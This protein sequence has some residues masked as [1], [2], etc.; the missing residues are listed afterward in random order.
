MTFG[1][2][3]YADAYDENQELVRTEKLTLGV[4]GDVVVKEFPSHVRIS[5][6][7]WEKH[8]Q[9]LIPVLKQGDW[10]DGSTET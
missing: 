4:Y 2:S 5:R 3:Y 8:K 1:K 6:E 10:K 7:D 9:R